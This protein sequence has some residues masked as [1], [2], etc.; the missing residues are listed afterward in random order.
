M[1]VEINN[2]RALM[3]SRCKKYFTPIP[4]AKNAQLSVVADFSVAS[5]VLNSYSR[6]EYHIS[7]RE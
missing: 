3:E 1:S 7:E 2:V 6:V 5:G 4:L